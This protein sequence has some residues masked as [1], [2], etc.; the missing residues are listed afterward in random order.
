MWTA[1]TEWSLLNAACSRCHDYKSQE[2]DKEQKGSAIR[3]GIAILL[4]MAGR[5]KNSRGA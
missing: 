4:R 5:E 2:A 3:A 1:T